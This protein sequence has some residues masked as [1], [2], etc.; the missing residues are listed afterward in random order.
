MAFSANN[1]R[2]VEYWLSAWKNDAPPARTDISPAKMK[3]LLPGLAILE[4]DG[5]G[6][7]ICRLAG[8]AIPMAVGLDPTG[9]D[10]V[11]LTPVQFREERI[12][13][14]RKVMAGAISRCVRRTMNRFDQTVLVED[15]QLPLS[16]GP[17]GVAQ[18]LYHAD[19]RPQTLDR[20]TPEILRG[21]GMAVDEAVSIIA[22]RAMRAAV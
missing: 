15:V 10:I 4:Y 21:L 5:K 12:A 20:S 6:S 7:A 17:E 8:S 14:Y 1:R 22:P 11:A 2:F 19:W 16:G 9:L 3:D 13:R 18:I